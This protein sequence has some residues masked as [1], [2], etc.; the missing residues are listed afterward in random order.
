[1]VLILLAVTIVS[2]SQTVI[3]YQTWTGASGCNIFGTSTNVPATIN[4]ASTNISH[5][6]AIGQPTYDNSNKSVNLASEIVNGSQNQGTEYRMTVNFKAGYSYNIT[7]NAARIMSSQS[8]PNVLLRLDLNN[9]GSG[10]NTQCNGTG[11]IDANGSGNLKKSNSVTSNS[12]SDYVF[13][14]SALS[15][16]Q[17]YLMVAAIPPAGS[18]Y[19]TILIRKITITETAPAAPATPLFSISR[20]PGGTTICGN[21]TTFTFT[22]N[23]TNNTSGGITGYTWNLGANNGWNYQGGAAPDAIPTATS[24]IQLTS[25]CGINPNPVSVT[26]SYG[27]ATYGPSSASVIDPV[28]PYVNLIEQS[29]KNLICSGSTNTYFIGGLPCGANV[30]Y[31]VDQSHVTGGTAP[32]S[33]NGNTISVTNPNPQFKGFITI[34]ATVI[35]ACGTR[36][37]SFSYY[38]S[39][40]PELPLIN[41]DLQ[42][43][44]DYSALC[45]N[46]GG[47]WAASSDAA[48]SYTWN[49]D[50]NSMTYYNG[51]STTSSLSLSTNY[52]FAGGWISVS[53]T[54]AC[55]TGPTNYKSI[56]LSNNCSY[57]RYSVSPNPASSSINISQDKTTDTTTQGFTDVEIADKSGNLKKRIKYSIGTHSS[58]IDISS[59]P[60]DTY[61]IRIN[62]GKNWEDHKILIVR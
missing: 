48:E 4:G 9:G 22:A 6:N 17:T 21:P 58:K 23:N 36:T 37:N 19:Q 59:L 12:F 35:T 54:N 7:V 53:A 28:I 18:V 14:Y 38:L 29:N 57:S 61:I 34:I 8:G 46:S 43:P 13:T 56:G 20:S 52:N 41:K 55:G 5:L 1:M 62:N 11:S 50:H 33:I 40:G 31:G 3:N 27:T 25:N 39:A 30:S 24:S 42:Y 44:N 2:F 10:N 45:P 16:A 26:V 49:W 15:A 51:G 47:A 60:A 32:Y